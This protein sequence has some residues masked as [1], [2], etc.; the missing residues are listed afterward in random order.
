MASLID[1]A[2]PAPRLGPARRLGRLARNEALWPG[3][4]GIAVFLAVWQGA[5]MLGLPMLRHVPSPLDVLRQLARVV[6]GSQ[7]WLSW[8]VSGRRV[9]L[10]YVIGVGLGV[11]LGLAMG[12]SRVFHGMGFPVLEVLRPIPPLA[13]VPLSILFWPTMEQTIVSIIFL[14]AFFTVVLNVLGGVEAIDV[15]YRRAAVSM[16]ARPWH[17]FWKIVL[18]ATAPSIVTG[19]AVG[20]GLTWE[21]VVAAEMIASIQAGLGF[22][23]WQAYVGGNIALIIVSMVSIGLAGLVS[24]TAIWL[25]GRRVTPWLRR[26]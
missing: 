20:M 18:P 11:P 12:M 3:L 16:G 2:A 25:L 9:L 8:Y 7:Y 5:S 1:D 4:A 26:T 14:G 19:M 6:Q 15:N 24:S 23:M 22:M 13:W 17:L 21:I 10:G